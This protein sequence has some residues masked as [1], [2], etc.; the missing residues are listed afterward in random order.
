MLK[1]SEMDAVV[2]TSPI[3]L[4]ELLATLVKCTLVLG[5]NKIKEMGK[6]YSNTA[7]TH[8]HAMGLEEEMDESLANFKGIIQT[9]R[10]TAKGKAYRQ[11]ASLCDG[12]HDR[13][14]MRGLGRPKGMQR[15][16]E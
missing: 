7:N 11:Q 3:E 8:E 12:R 16:D 15:H 14:S 6:I 13:I 9:L 4:W 5:P 1:V 10:A 2:Q